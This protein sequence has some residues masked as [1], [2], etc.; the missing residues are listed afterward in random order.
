MPGKS[1]VEKTYNL[2]LPRI[3]GPYKDRLKKRILPT[4]KNKTKVYKINPSDFKE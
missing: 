3:K 1:S 2:L 4:S